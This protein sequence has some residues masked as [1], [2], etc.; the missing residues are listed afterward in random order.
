MPPKKRSFFGQYLSDH[1]IA[2][3]SPSSS[4]L[5]RR[6]IRHL[7]PA[8]SRI[9]VELGPGDG[10]ATKALLAAMPKDSRYLAIE[11]NHD[12]AADL[13]GL[14]DPRLDIIEGDARRLQDILKEKGIGSVDAVIASIPFTYL[15]KA[16]RRAL[17]RSVKML[18]KPEGRFVIFHQYSPLMVPY[19]K[20][21]FGRVKVE[22]EPLNLFPC[23][24][25]DSRNA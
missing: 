20:Q 3:V 17:V 4:H 7:D 9:V 25:I 10:A 2:A 12:F 5:I 11:K 6:L 23:F 1:D 21:A 15:N 18:L 22:F 24:L 8:N 19:V 16:E 14:G 13:A